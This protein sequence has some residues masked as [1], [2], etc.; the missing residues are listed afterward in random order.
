MAADNYIAGKEG[1]VKVG[2][3]GGSDDD[4][5]FA[6]DKWKAS[7]KCSL[8]KITN[9][10]TNGFQR[11]LSCIVSATISVSGPY[12]AG[13]YDAANTV[14]MTGNSVPEAGFTV[15]GS[16]TWILGFETSLFLEIVA[17]ISS[18]DVDND[19]ESN[20]KVS[21]TAESDGEFFAFIN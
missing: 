3:S 14:S 21:I 12:N 4:G 8:T 20:A 19:V 2:S 16:Y 13:N 5:L 11:M 15:G 9:F 7:L 1:Y 18:L 6:F 10:T 17:I